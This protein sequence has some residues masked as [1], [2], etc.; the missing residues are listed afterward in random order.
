MEALK[1]EARPDPRAPGKFAVFV[2]S[3]FPAVAGPRLFKGTP[4]PAEVT[5][6]TTGLDRPTALRR[7][8]AWEKYLAREG[9]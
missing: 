8:E 4:P 2:L 5:E 6:P 3:V 1:A 9:K 7:A